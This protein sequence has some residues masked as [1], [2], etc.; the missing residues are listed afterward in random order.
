MQYVT[1][2]RPE[3]FEWRPVP[4]A[5]ASAISIGRNG[6]VWIVGTEAMPGGREVLRWNGRSWLP[7]GIGAERVA[8][9]P[10]GS[11]WLLDDSSHLHEPAADGW[12]RLDQTAV[13]VSVGADGSVWIIAPGASEDAANRILRR[14]GDGWVE[15]DSTPTPYGYPL[16][17]P[18]TQTDVADLVDAPEMPIR[19]AVTAEGLPWV[20]NADGAMY[21]RLPG[22]WQ[23]LAEEPAAEIAIGFDGNC[24]IV[25]ADERP[26]GFGIYRYYHG[27]DW[28]CYDGAAVKIAVDPDGLP[29]RIDAQGRIFNQHVR[30]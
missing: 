8:V 27:T 18:W 5:T 29:W 13:D 2:L 16:A 21:R 9:A 15:G 24:W 17:L 26:D 30:L 10:D 14:R 4:G 19:L 12:R 22:A 11:A 20:V 25:G 6:A 7:Q 1:G 23:L 28:D 3:I